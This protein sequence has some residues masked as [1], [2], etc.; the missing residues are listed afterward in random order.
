MARTQGMPEVTAP[1]PK[2]NEGVELPKKGV[3]VTAALFTIAKVEDNL[4]SIDR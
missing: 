4:M 3:G 2:L 1:E